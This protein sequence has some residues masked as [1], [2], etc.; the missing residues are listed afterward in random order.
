MNG[1]DYGLTMNQIKF[2]ENYLLSGVGGQ[3]YIEA[4]STKEKPVKMT[5]AYT[6]SSNLLKKENVQEYLN[7]RRAELMK[8]TTMEASDIIEKLVEMAN[9]PTVKASDRLKSLELLGKNLAMFTDRVEN[10]GTMDIE[11]NLDGKELD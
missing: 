7:D 2:C 6:S 4:Y 1:K 8:Q 3:S 9:D 10:N 11:I 5:T